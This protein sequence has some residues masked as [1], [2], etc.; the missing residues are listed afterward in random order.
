MNQ[1]KQSIW[2]NG[3]NK[4]VITS[5]T[6]SEPQIR[7]LAMAHTCESLRDISS[8]INLHTKFNS[9]HS[10]TVHVCKPNKEASFDVEGILKKVEL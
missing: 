6:Y 10:M 2:P 5:I 8:E 4:E 7:A 9:D 1:E 3:Q